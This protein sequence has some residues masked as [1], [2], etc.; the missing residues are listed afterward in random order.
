MPFADQFQ[1]CMNLPHEGEVLNDFLVQSIKISHRNLLDGVY[2]FPI[3][4]IVIGE[5]GKQDLLKAFKPVFTKVISLF[6][7]YGNLYQCRNHKLQIEKIAPKTFRLTTTGIGCRIYPK[8][9]LE[10]FIQFLKDSTGFFEL[11]SEVLIASYLDSY[12]KKLQC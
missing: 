3:E 4:L 6:T 2:F 5:G 9:E 1:R 11:N 7:E 10:A 8:Q 12:Q